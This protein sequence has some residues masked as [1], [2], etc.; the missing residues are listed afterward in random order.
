MKKSMR[1]LLAGLLL[2]GVPLSGFASNPDDILG[3]WYTENNDARVEI[4]RCKEKYCGRIVWL[5]DPDYPAG[6]R[7]GTPG[8]S[9]KDHN[10]PDPELRTRPVLGLT[11]MHDF[12]FSGGNEWKG[13]RLYDP[14][15][16]KT[17]RGKM[18]LVSPGRLNLRGFVGIS[19][20]GRTSKWTRRREGS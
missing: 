11:I 10:N 4:F 13:G 20:L 6:S 8:T 14:E 7:E 18:K 19:L 16:G 3:T 1:A 12:R 2:F 9:K 17:Y 15:K 5:K